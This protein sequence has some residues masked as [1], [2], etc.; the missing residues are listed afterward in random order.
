M[1]LSNFYLTTYKAYQNRDAN[2]FDNIEDYSDYITYTLLNTNFNT[3]GEDVTA[4]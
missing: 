1:S 2:R 4:V 3:T